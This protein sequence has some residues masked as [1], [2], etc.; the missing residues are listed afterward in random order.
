MAT[1][2]PSPENYYDFLV[3][4]SGNSLQFNE[5]V[6]QQLHT[7][8]YDNNPSIILSVVGQPKSGK[9]SLMNY[10]LTVLRKDESI[11][12]KHGFP[13]SSNDGIRLCN[14]QKF[15]EGILAYTPIQCRVGE[16]TFL[17]LDIWSLNPS[18]STY[19]K[20]V[21]LCLTV[22]SVVIFSESWEQTAPVS[23]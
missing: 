23:S 18:P 11:S 7:T 22:S 1:N 3:R 10:I 13:L 4:V 14:N 2:N 15:E 9:T 6:W 8:E 16:P 17:L 12:T 20:L 5:D 19:N 21:D